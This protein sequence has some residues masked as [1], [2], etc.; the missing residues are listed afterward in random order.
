MSTAR[1][2]QVIIIGAG[3]GGLCL[4]QGLF[5]A[6]LNVRVFERDRTAIDRLQGY[7]LTISA[8]GNRALQACLPKATFS[9]S[10][11]LRPNPTPP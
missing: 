9:A 8:T 7:R 11:P 3:T 2:L 5:A 6:G 10:S 1:K 4:A